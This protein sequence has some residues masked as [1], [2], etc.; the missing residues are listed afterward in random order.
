MLNNKR[1]HMNIINTYGI[2]GSISML[3][4]VC[5]D[6]TSVSFVYEYKDKTK[7]SFTSKVVSI[8]YTNEIDNYNG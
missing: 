6:G 7:Q 1:R 2:A 8:S 5:R 3:G 4:K